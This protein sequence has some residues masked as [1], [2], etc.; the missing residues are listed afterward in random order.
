MCITLVHVE[1]ALSADIERYVYLLAL[2]LVCN[3]YLLRMFVNWSN[4]VQAFKA[5]QLWHFS[6]VCAYDYEIHAFVARYFLL[7]LAIYYYES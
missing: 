2:A 6:K 1:K 4:K 7:S 3:F 5:C